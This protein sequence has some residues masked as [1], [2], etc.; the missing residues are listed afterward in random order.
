[1]SELSE[2]TPASAGLSS[3]P[4]PDLEQQLS[5]LRGLTIKL[6]SGLIALTWLMIF[7]MFIQVWRGHKDVSAI[8]W[9]RSS[10]ASWSTTPAP[11]RTSSLCWPNIRFRRRRP[12]PRRP[13]PIR[14]LLR[15]RLHLRSNRQFFSQKPSDLRPVAGFLV[16]RLKK[17]KARNRAAR[18]IIAHRLD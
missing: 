6:Q 4:K 12:R 16:L 18:L 7:F 2:N 14:H 1:M 11:T 10:S 17:K 8:R 15:R 9:C 13:L 3:T 5:E